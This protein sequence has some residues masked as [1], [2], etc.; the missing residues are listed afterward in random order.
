MAPKCHCRGQPRGLHPPSPP[1]RGVNLKALNQATVSWGVGGPAGARDRCLTVGA[2]T[3]RVLG[4]NRESGTGRADHRGRPGPGG[5][6]PPPAEAARPGRGAPRARSPMSRRAHTHHTPH[7][8]PGSPS[9][10]APR[11]CALPSPSG[12][13]TPTRPASRGSKTLH[14]PEFLHVCGR[15][16]RE[17]KREGQQARGV[18]SVAAPRGAGHRGHTRARRRGTP[19]WRVARSLGSPARAPPAPSPRPRSLGLSGWRPSNR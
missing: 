12:A 8:S 4:D 19:A 15:G 14:S 1:P 6:P 7:P 5:A 2:E 10:G 13:P 9:A 16:L 17:T 3:R 18:R 11:R